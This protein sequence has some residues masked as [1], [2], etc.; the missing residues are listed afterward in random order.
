L[1]TKTK[2]ILKALRLR[3]LP[4]AVSG[5]LLGSFLASFYGQFHWDIF[6]LTT[7]TAV[8]L[9]ILS[10]LA[11][12]YGDGIKGTD[13]HHRI[14]PKRAMQSGEIKVW[15]M[16]TAIAVS[17]II[18]L[19]SGIWLIIKGT[20]N[21]EST[22]LWL[23][24]VLGLGAIISALKYTI[25]NKPYGYIGLGDFFVF[26]WFGI[27]GVGGTFFLHANAFDID[28]LLPAA[29]MGLFC[30]GV[31]NINNMRDRISDDLAGKKTLVVRIG[32][33]AAKL[34]QISLILLAIATSSIFIFRH[35]K[36]AVQLLFLLPIPFMLR[37]LYRLVNIQEPVL[38]DPF[39]KRLS[40]ET[41]F[42]SVHMG[43]GLILTNYVQI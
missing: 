15:E 39:L 42:F 27:I 35:Y 5:T 38:F 12:D 17:V 11:N 14:G 26:L 8:S 18:S 29:S 41:F 20:Q 9:Q 24:V 19:V 40:I 2:A 32:E 16:K 10:N 43:V 4:L 23:F 1:N 22:Y 36:G 33:K 3:T 25:G 21:V 30:V 34:Y 31:L 28:I 7:I 6:A 37:N 13:N